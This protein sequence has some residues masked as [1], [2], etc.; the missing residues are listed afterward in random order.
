M[1]AETNAADLYKTSHL[2]SFRIT[3]SLPFWT[4]RHFS[5]APLCA[6]FLLAV[7]TLSICAL[8]TATGYSTLSILRG[9]HCFHAFI[10]GQQIL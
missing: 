9:I 1:E 6:C 5:L 7:F 10:A 2:L 8:Y 4:F 3:F